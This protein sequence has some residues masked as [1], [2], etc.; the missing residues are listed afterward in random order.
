M[1]TSRFAVSRRFSAIRFD[2]LALALLTCLWLLGNWRTLTP[3]A[4]D[5]WSISGG[6]FSAH[7]FV[8]SS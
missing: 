5:Q 3:N 2:L 4:A 8:Y 6:D 1:T 7:S